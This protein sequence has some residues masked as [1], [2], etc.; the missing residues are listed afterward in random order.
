MRKTRKNYPLTITNSLL[1]F[2]ACLSLVSYPN[3]VISTTP[4]LKSSQ[5]VILKPGMKGSEVQV[6]QMQL[7]ALGYYKTLIDG[8]YGIKTKNAVLEFQKSQG[9]KR[10]D[11]ITDL[12][13]QTILTK[14]LSSQSKPKPSPIPVVTPASTISID[15]SKSP[16]NQTDFF[17]WSLLG[18][19]LLITIGGVIYLIKRFSK[20][21]DSEELEPQKLLSASTENNGKLLLTSAQSQPLPIPTEIETL[22]TLETNK[23]F[24]QFNEFDTLMKDLQC[25][26]VKK[27]RKAIWNLGHKGDSRAVKPL[28]KMMIDADSQHQDLIVTSLTEIGANTLKPINRALAISM[29]DENPQ[30]RKNAIRDLV[31]IY[32]MIRQMTKIVL[33]AMEDPDPEVQKTAEYALNRITHIPRTRNNSILKDQQTQNLEE[34]S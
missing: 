31:R 32:D 27:R 14:A 9:L 30:V 13:T 34:E 17:W 2:A 26:D 29:Q 28:L 10:Q 11:G 21:E 3:I 1:I 19:G 7:K 23:L 12:N 15:H 16:F 18:L 33:Y 4:T 22:G 8:D 24:S 5:Q 6:L 25:D 20:V